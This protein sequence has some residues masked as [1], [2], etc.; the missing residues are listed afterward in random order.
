M[1]NIRLVHELAECIEKWGWQYHH[2]GI[3]TQNIMPDEQ[4]IPHLKCFISGF[5]SSPF[6]IEWMRF[7]ADSP[8]PELIQ[9]L[10]HVA[11]MVPDLD[12]EL[13]N[14]NFKIIS[15]P[16]I[17]T[18]DIQVVMIEHNG[19]PIELMEMANGSHIEKTVCALYCHNHMGS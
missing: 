16:C 3:P 6:G 1:H 8:A 18:C 5:S 19:A 4:Y 12:F 15:A 11:F 13:V 9:T 14:R 7:E 10:P 2:T 17:P